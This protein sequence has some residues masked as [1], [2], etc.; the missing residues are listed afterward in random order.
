MAGRSGD[1]DEALL[2]AVRIIRILYQSTLLPNPRGLDRPEEI[3]EGGGERDKDRSIRLVNGFL[4][5]AWDDLRSLCLFSYHRLRDFILVTARAVNL[6][7]HSSLR[8]L[9][10]IWEALKY[11]GSL[12]QYWGLELKKS[13]ISLLDTIAIVVAEGTDSIIRF[14]QRLCRAICNVPTRIRQD[15]EAASL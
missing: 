5:L 13:A 3:E 12:V 2:Q 4:A 9:Q 8:G 11:L 15:F 14:I 10:R 7:G 1:S 6:L